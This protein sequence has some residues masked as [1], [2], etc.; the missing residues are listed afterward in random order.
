M[1]T[2]GFAASTHAQASGSSAKF[3]LDENARKTITIIHN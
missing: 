1:N 3:L 2:Y